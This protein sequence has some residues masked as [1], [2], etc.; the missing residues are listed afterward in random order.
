MS[1]MRV[2][3]TK[4]FTVMSNHH[5]REK[6]MS[7]KAK[8]LLSLMLSLPDDWN[9][10]ISGLVTL[11]K[12][13]KDSVMSALNELEKF[14][15]LK[16]TRLTNSKGQFQGVEYDIYEQPQPQTPVSEEQNEGKQNEE[17]SH[18]ENPPQLNT[19]LTN[20][21][22]NKEFKEQN[23]NGELYEII[24]NNVAFEALL[25]YYDAYV[26]MRD[27]IGQP[28]SPS[29]LEMLIQRCNRLAKYNINK[30][31]VM[32]EAA[33]INGW[34]NV[35]SPN[36]HEAPAAVKENDTYRKLYEFYGDDD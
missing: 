5:F 6:G 11:S 12:D 26:D 16:R 3:K 29:G 20:N 27:D 8:G 33:T 13:G 7:L 23:T 36:D 25:P 28:I 21:E 17:K 14:G 35:Y 24:R 30:Q 18:A 15:Y 10:S 19:K 1:I 4:N 31:R 9:Y 34:K 2:H 32:L 22:F